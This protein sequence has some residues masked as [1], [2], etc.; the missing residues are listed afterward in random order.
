MNT[1]TNETLLFN[2]P[3]TAIKVVSAFYHELSLKPAGIARHDYIA[4]VYDKYFDT[5]Y[6][7]MGGTGN[8]IES[9]QDF[10]DFL[11]ATFTKLPNL[12]VDAEELV[13]AGDKVTVK[14]KLHE[15]NAGVEIN[16]LTLYH[17]ENGKI[18]NRYAYSD[19]GF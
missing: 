12:S 13:A 8:K 3:T 5:S 9:F 16:Y 7:Q 17:V 2:F 15:K 10:K 19:G 14:V 6:Y 18:M 11:I 4:N 1:Q